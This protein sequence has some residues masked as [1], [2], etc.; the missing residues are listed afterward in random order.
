VNDSFYYCPSVDGLGTFRMGPSHVSANSYSNG[1]D[2]TFDDAT[3]MTF[4]AK[5][6]SRATLSAARVAAKRKYVRYSITASY[7]SVRASKWTRWKNKPVL[8][9]KLAANGTWVTVARPSTNRL[10]VVV[11][12]RNAPAAARYQVAVPA[13][14]TTGNSVSAQRAVGRG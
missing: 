10:G 14:S 4:S 7:Y 3:A 6:S 9:Q 5:Q 1:A 11:L 12:T 13:S 2:A 8:L